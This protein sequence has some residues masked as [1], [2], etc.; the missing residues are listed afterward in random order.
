MEIRRLRY[1]ETKPSSC[2]EQFFFDAEIDG[3]LHKSKQICCG[4]DKREEKRVFYSFI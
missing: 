4:T 1:T 3:N 2:L